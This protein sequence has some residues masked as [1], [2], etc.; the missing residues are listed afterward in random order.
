[1]RC[2]FVFL[3]LLKHGETRGPLFRMQTTWICMSAHAHRLIRKL[4]VV[5]STVLINSVSVKQRPRSGCT[6]AQPDLGLRSSHHHENM[7]I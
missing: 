3:R 7:P 4:L 2:V 5:S 6:C 1:M